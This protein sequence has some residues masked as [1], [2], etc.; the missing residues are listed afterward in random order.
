MAIA[1]CSVP[2]PHPHAVGCLVRGVRS[3]VHVSGLSS[4]DADRGRAFHREVIPLLGRNLF[5][6]D[7]RVCTWGDAGGV[8]RPQIRDPALV[9]F[10]GRVWDIVRILA[11]APPD[12]GFVWS[13]DVLCLGWVDRHLHVH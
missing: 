11:I 10:D 6:G 2:E 9:C 3:A 5:L 13:D 1:W 7:S 8:A 4:Y 12:Y